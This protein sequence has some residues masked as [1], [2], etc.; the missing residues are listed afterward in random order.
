MKF[1]EPEDLGDG[2]YFCDYFCLLQKVKVV[3]GIHLN[4][5]NLTFWLL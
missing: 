4:I 5:K 1:P 3:S 2:D